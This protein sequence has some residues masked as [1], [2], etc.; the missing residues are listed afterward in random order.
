L[1]PPKGTASLT[2]QELDVAKVIKDFRNPSVGGGIRFSISGDLQSEDG[3]RVSL[4]D[5]EKNGIVTH[6]LKEANVDIVDVER[7]TF[8]KLVM[9]LFRKL[10]NGQIITLSESIQ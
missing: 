1:V 4:E 8:R 5:V 7:Q 2:A 6:G 10:K 3:E 9:R